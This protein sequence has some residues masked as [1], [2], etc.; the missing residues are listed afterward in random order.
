MP[1]PFFTR[2]LR[3]R[4]PD[5]TGSIDG[6]RLRRALAADPALAGRVTC[7]EAGTVVLTGAAAGA[8]PASA[9][10]RQR[11]ELHLRLRLAAE[12]GERAATTVRIRWAGSGEC[13]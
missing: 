10:E 9:K 6:G 2:L 8:P 13:I 12:F 11:W 3:C 4:V 5:P 7:D 1:A